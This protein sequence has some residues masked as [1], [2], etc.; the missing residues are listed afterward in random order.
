MMRQWK[1]YPVGLILAMALAGCSSNS[2]APSVSM[3]GGN[4]TTPVS[5][6]TVKYKAQPLT[7]TIANGVTTGS[8]P[9]TYVFEVATDSSFGT[10]VYSSSKVAQGSGQTSV[11]LD[12]MLDGGKT[13]YWRAQTFDGDTAGPYGQALAFN[14]KPQVTMTV[15]QVMSPTNNGTTGNMAHFSVANTV[16]SNAVRPINYVYEIS[17]NAA[18]TDKVETG[19]VPEGDG[20]TS[21]DSKTD[22]GSGNSYYWRV[23]AA[24]SDGNV[25]ETSAVT[26]FRTVAFDPKAARFWNN[27][28]IGS[29]AET[30]KI[31]MVD[32]SNG[33]VEVDFDRRDGPNRWPDVPFGTGN[34][35]YTL[36]LC[37]NLGGQWHCS[38]AIQ[39]W[40]GRELGAGGGMWN[41]ADDW[42]YDVRWG[43]MAGWQPKQGETVAVFV[44]SGNLRDSNNWKIEERSNFLLIPWGTNYYR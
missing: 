23:W 12:R 13:Y 35:E 27:P 41:I 18:F 9:V 19:T 14:L 15:P 17:R 37:G 42:Y 5:N 36:G 38:A 39:F 24:D 1:V 20:Q 33:L 31:T 8:G 44:A 26:P 22:L 43:T 4:A 6:A 10:K 40:Y 3:A 32:F 28:P 21:W 2:P 7:L 11:T 25:S 30:A 34:L 29:W 16:T